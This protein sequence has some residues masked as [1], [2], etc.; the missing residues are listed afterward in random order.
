MTLF[1]VAP[2]PETPPDVQGGGDA[3]V[4]RRCQY[5]GEG[6]QWCRWAAHHTVMCVGCYEKG[7]LRLSVPEWKREHPGRLLQPGGSRDNAEQLDIRPYRHTVPM[8]PGLAAMIDGLRAHPEAELVTWL[9]LTAA[10]WI[11]AHP[12]ADPWEA[13]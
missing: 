1:D 13:L 6:T 4:F 2:T 7:G 5:C 10:A 3:D 11:D 9:R 12:D 8:W